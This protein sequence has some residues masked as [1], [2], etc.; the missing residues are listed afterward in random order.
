[1]NIDSTDLSE[2]NDFAEE[3]NLMKE[4]GYHK[5]IVSLIA[6]STVKKSLRLIVEY[7]EH[8]DLFNYLRKRQTNQYLFK[9]LAKINDG[10]TRKYFFNGKKVKISDFGLTRKIN[11]EFNY[12][13]KKKRCLPV[14]WMSVEAIFDQLFKSFSDVYDIML[15][16]WNEDPLQ[17]LTFK[18]LRKYFDKVMSQGDCYLNFEMDQ[19]TSPL[20]SSYKTDNYNCNTME[21]SVFLKSLLVKSI[22][23]LK[24]LRDK[25]NTPLRD[26][27]T[28]FV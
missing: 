13:S 10:D 26:W 27:Y 17:R 28:S 4:N 5:N 24:K 9:F 20:F 3:M 8:G 1:M 18:T 12:M 6:C 14:K 21:D 19:N 16:Y 22:E 15:Q 11:D 2:L 23:E 25:S 7:M